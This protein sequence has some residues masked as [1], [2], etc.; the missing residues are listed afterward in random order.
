MADTP[1]LYK[2]AIISVPDG[3]A[4]P[5]G[6]IPLNAAA[7]GGA[8]SVNAIEGGINGNAFDF[9]RA[10][11]GSA[12]G[13]TI[14]VFR[15][16]RATLRDRHPF[17]AEPDMVHDVA[18]V[19]G[20]KTEEEAYLAF[21]DILQDPDLVKSWAR[22][23]LEA[24]LI[25]PDDMTNAVRLG[26]AWKIAVGWALDFKRAS[27]GTVELTPFEA[28]KQVAENTG[29]A[30]AAKQAYAA[31]HFTGDKVYSETS[32][33]QTEPDTAILHDLLGRDP[34]EGELAAFRAGYMQTA[35][36]NPT[37]STSTTHFED[38]EAKNRTTVVTGG[39]DERQAAIDASYS[40]SPEVAANQQ[41]TTYY[42]ALVNAL[43]AAV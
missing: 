17:G 43:R 30:I 31:D 21:A 9:A 28:A 35:K 1:Y 42:D 4:P 13:P 33:N 22:I 27:G 37:V 40:A 36:E 10:Q 25:G 8:G 6:A 26:A 34:S 23:A 11:T 20:Q 15:D 41:A 24:G 38:G 5:A 18:Y 16:K 39:F 29:S 32:V 2:G 19:P 12:N 3:Q 7:G 14:P